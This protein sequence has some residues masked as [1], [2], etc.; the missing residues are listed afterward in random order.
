MGRSAPA[1]LSAGR[2][3][4][5][6]RPKRARPPPGAR[7]TRPAAGGT[8][9]KLRHR[10]SNPESLSRHCRVSW[11]AIRP[12]ATHATN[13]RL[14]KHRNETRSAV[15]SSPVIGTS[16]GACRWCSA[17]AFGRWRWTRSGTPRASRRSRS[18]TAP[19]ASS[20]CGSRTPRSGRCPWTRAGP[21]VRWTRPPPRGIRRSRRSSPRPGASWTSTTRR[22]PR[23]CSTTSSNRLSRS[24]TGTT[25]TTS[26]RW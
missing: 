26:A 25:R 24:T 2:S 21:C 16:R 6:R 3:S 12:R 18:M 5:L 9:A 14:S 15:S 19:S 10:S 20:S 11:T 1:R 23:G 22:R 17:R 4:W 7:A 8:W 13:L